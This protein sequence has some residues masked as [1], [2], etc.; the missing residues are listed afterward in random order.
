M[1][2]VDFEGLG[3]QV[4]EKHVKSKMGQVGFEGG[5]CGRGVE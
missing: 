4:L 2:K 1:G 3:G 5:G